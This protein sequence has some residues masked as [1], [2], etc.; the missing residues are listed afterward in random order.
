MLPSLDTSGRSGSVRLI[1]FASSDKISAL[2]S[3]QTRAKIALIYPWGDDASTLPQE[4]FFVICRESSEGDDLLVS[5]E[6]DEFNGEGKSTNLKQGL[7]YIPQSLGDYNKWIENPPKVELKL[8]SGLSFPS[9]L[10]AG[11]L[12]S[13][14]INDYSSKVSILQG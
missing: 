13:E 9:V 7:A 5:D 6:L 2:V 4:T 3:A 8:P 1:Q 12:T 11:S 10:T 14:E